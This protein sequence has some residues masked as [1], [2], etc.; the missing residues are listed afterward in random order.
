M[1]IEINCDGCGKII[2]D[3]IDVERR[4]R[5]CSNCF[6]QGGQKYNM[7]VRHSSQG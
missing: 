1:A 2:E 5:V 7:E 4:K 3:W 6:I